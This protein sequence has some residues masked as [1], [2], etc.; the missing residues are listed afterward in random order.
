MRQFNL[1]FDLDKSEDFKNL[2]SWVRFAMFYE[3]VGDL[4][5]LFDRISNK[6]NASS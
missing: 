6:I 3:E 4:Q 2:L 1:K 5:H